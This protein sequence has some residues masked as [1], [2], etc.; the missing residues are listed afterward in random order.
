MVGGGSEVAHSWIGMP[1]LPND[2]LKFRY[3]ER[4]SKFT[5]KQIINRI[6]PTKQNCEKLFFTEQK[7]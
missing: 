5:S 7:C 2:T 3:P 1:L 6:R 4:M